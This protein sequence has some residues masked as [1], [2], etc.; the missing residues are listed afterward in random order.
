MRKNSNSRNN[1]HVMNIEFFEIIN[2][3]LTI[4]LVNSGA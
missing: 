1:N 2:G 3:I 4:L